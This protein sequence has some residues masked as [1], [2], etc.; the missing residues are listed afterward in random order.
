MEYII[1]YIYSLKPNIRH[2]KNH[3]VFSSKDDCRN[4]V[5]ILGNVSNKKKYTYVNE[6]IKKGI[7]GVVSANPLNEKKLFKK[8]VGS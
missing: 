5:L 7:L 3:I 4:K 2:I 1:K 8:N 6:A